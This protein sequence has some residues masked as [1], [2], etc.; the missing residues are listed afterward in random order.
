ML[1]DPLKIRVI[2]NLIEHELLSKKYRI[3]TKNNT[4]ITAV[5]NSKERGTIKWDRHNGWQVTTSHYLD[6]LKMAKQQ[7]KLLLK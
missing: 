2:V 6:F 1:D 5:S 4:S 7:A 3:V